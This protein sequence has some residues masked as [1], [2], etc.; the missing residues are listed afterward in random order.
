MMNSLFEAAEQE[1]LD[2]ARPL[3][4]RI[5]PKSLDDFVGQS[6]FLSPGSV[7]DRVLRSGRFTSLVFYGAPGTG[8]TTLA[9]LVA[10]TV[11]AEFVRLNAAGCG[12]KE[13]RDELSA[14]RNR[15]EASGRRTVLFVDELHHFNRTQQDVLL[16]DV[17]SGVVTLIGATTSNPFFALN[18]ALVSRSHV[19]E[20][21]PISTDELIPV[22]ERALSDNEFG[23]GRRKIDVDAEALRF[24]ADVSDGDVRK[25]L[26]SLEL[27][28]ESLSNGEPLTSE[29]AAAAVQKKSLLY[30]ASGDQHYDVISA[31][32]KS[33]RGADAD[34]AIYWLAR[35]LESGEDPRFVARRLVIAAS[36]DVGNAD[37]QALLVAE[38]AAAATDRLGM[39][40]C[41]IPL[42]QATTYVALAPKSNA[43]YVAVNKAMDDVRSGRLL[44][45]PPHLR[46]KHSPGVQAMGDEA[47]YRYPHDYDG[48]WVAQAYLSEARTYYEPTDRGHEEEHRRRLEEIRSRR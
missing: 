42:A 32:I 3:A 41:R 31:Y 24:I 29:V 22:L 27:A 19:F 39:P 2:A 38:A 47:T 48:G 7:L 8:K 5:R 4:D 1:N 11:D 34:A 46:D 18:A 36:E 33:L 20:F 21:R 17:E 44:P 16:P 12:V 9:Y 30:D 10:K 40:E 35:I 28:V 45:V 43:S 26:S 25:A 14:A 37:P 23:Y 6:H 15:L 13:L